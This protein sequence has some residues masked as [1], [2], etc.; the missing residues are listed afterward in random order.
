M[1]VP[2][3]IHFV[4]WGYRICPDPVIGP[5][6]V[7]V[8]DL[9]RPFLAGIVKFYCFFRLPLWIIYGKYYSIVVYKSYSSDDDDENRC[10]PA[11]YRPGSAYAL[12]Q[13]YP[14]LT[15]FSVLNRIISSYSSIK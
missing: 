15:T 11:S 2:D 6:K 10:C 7:G 13:I 14:I 12:K 5:C 1:G 8:P 4:K 9:G 3:P